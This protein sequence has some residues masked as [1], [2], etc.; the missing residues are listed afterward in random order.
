MVKGLDKLMLIE[1]VD[2]S[3]LT[4]D[5]WM[6]W[7]DIHP[8]DPHKCVSVGFIVSENKKGVILV[9][10]IADVEHEDNRHVYGGIMIPQGAIVL[11]RKLK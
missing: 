1:W 5:E 6:D 2:S 10:T 7:N 8:A 11:K 3:R 9:P 4:G